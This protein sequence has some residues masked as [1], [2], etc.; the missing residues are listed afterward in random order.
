MDRD[1]TQTSTQQSPGLW[2]L[3]PAAGTGERMRAAVPKQYLQV[4]GQ[5]LIVHSL[6]ALLELQ[7]L[8]GVMVVIAPDDDHWQQVTGLP[9]NVFTT[10]G[11]ATRVHSVCNG[12]RALQPQ[13]NSGDWVLVHDAARPCV[14]ATD[15]QRL[16]AEVD[17]D[18]NGGLM[19][20]PVTDTVKRAED[21]RSQ[22]T[23]A[24]EQLWRAQTPQ[25]F[26]ISDLLGAIEQALRTGTTT[27]DEANAMELIGRK[28][29]LV[30][31][32]ETNI[33]VTHP[34]DLK[35]VR[36]YLGERETTSAAMKKAGS[37]K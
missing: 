34:D 32:S 20:V 22:A 26:P 17:W 27:T 37:L 28:P 19:A 18:S 7:G 15:I 1:R 24:R 3:I 33:K 14:Q 4:L 6:R 36:D 21:M 8:R 10:I 13:C 2:G 30:A 23:V 9:G 29:L 12:L 25:L 5:P 11:G 31:G 16:I 35:L